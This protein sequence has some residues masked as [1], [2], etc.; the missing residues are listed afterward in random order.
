MT[1]PAIPLLSRL[2]RA[3]LK[4]PIEPSTRT[5]TGV[6]TSSSSVSSALA[7]GSIIEIGQP[8]TVNDAG[9]LEPWE[10]DPYSLHVVGYALETTQAEADLIRFVTRDGIHRQRLS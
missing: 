5:A 1:L 3:S 2:R 10:G 9:Y 4:T 7:S 8:L 6:S